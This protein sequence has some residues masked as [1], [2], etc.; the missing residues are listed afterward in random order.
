MTPPYK[1]ERK[2][3]K[4]ADESFAI[5]A[6]HAHNVVSDGAAAN[7]HIHL[8]VTLSA[9]VSLNYLLAQKHGRR[10]AL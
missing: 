10:A 1:H 6:T 2:L 5:R 7:V 3:T 9:E 8:N 4:I